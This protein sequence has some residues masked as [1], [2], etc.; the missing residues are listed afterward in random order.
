VEAAWQWVRCDPRG[1]ALYR[2]LLHC[3]GTAQK[4][5]VGVARHLGI[6][7]WRLRVTGGRE[8]P[9]FSPV[10]RGREHRVPKSVPRRGR[11]TALDAAPCPAGRPRTAPA[12]TDTTLLEDTD[13]ALTVVTAM[14]SDGPATALAASRIGG[15]DNREKNLWP[16]AT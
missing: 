4:A 11:G 8:S 7:L 1:K 10:A 12:G 16:R 9:R 2:H 13:N 6:L 15:R 5:I 3:T 14:T